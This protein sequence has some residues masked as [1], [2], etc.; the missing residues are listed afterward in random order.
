MAL[1]LNNAASIESQGTAEGTW[2]RI[3]PVAPPDGVDSEVGP[4][5][6]VNERVALSAFPG[7]RDAN[8][9]AATTTDDASSAMP[10]MPA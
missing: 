10:A 4:A 6:A 9:S 5:S 2:V 1:L 3:D 7:A 8:S